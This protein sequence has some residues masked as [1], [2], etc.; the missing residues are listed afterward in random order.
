[1]ARGHSVSGKPGGEV[2]GDEGGRA[3]QAHRAVSLAVRAEAAQRVGFGERHHRRKGQRSK[4]VGGDDGGGAVGKADQ[5]R[6]MK[7][8][9]LAATMAARSRS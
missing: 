2:A 6:A 5:D 1:M 7:L 3:P 8:A 4:S 9:Q